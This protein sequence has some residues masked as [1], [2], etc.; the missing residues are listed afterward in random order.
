MRDFY[1]DKTVTG[2]RDKTRVTAYLEFLSFVTII[3]AEIDSGVQLVW[4]IIVGLGWTENKALIE[5]DGNGQ[6]EMTA[7][8]R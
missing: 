7:D 8:S 4:R 5:V 3:S 6:K 2:H 1:Y